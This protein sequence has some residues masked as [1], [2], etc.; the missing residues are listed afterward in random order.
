M[1]QR[2][3][4]PQAT[5]M[6]VAITVLAKHNGDLEQSFDEL[7]REEVGSLGTFTRGDKALWEVT[8]KVLRQ[9]VCGDEGFRSNTTRIR[10]ALRF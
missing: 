6:E 7:W 9:E 4:Q 2:S 10:G 8:L 5:E 1:I 3:E